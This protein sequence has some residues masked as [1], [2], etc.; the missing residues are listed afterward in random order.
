MT[1]EMFTNYMQTIF[2]DIQIFLPYALMLFASIWG[3]RI[4]IDFF[5]SIAR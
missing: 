4:A 2:D 5:K 1:A 3:L